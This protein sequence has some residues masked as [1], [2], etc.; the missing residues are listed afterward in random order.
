MM[1]TKNNINKMFET[2]SNRWSDKIAFSVEDI[3]VML[4]IP[5]STVAQMCREGKLKVFK[6]GRHYRITRQDLYDYIETQKDN[7][8]I[9]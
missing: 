6:V 5:I 8:I 3:H 4:D 2:N 7:C 1:N 9:I